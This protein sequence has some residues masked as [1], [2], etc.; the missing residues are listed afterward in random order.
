M[1][2]LK[3]NTECDLTFQLNI[4]GSA[5]TPNVRFTLEN[6]SVFCISVKGRIEGNKAIVRTPILKDLKSILNKGQLKASLEVI[7]GDNYFVPW[8]DTVNI[9]WPIEVLSV[10]TNEVTVTSTSA[11]VQLLTV[12]EVKPEI[13]KEVI[14]EESPQPEQEPEVIP[15]SIKEEEAILSKLDIVE[16]KEE[17][18]PIDVSKIDEVED[19]PKKKETPSTFVKPEIKEGTSDIE[20][21]LSD[22]PDSKSYINSLLKAQ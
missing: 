1:M 8:E 20:F 15:E 19:I 7:V 11:P 4:E 13:V 6:D 12:E 16:T 18:K 21:F 17:P 5:Q 2:N 3:V 9:V 22:F 14:V 10:T